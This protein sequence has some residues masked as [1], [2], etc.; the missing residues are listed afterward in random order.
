MKNE[1][2]N[3]ICLYNTELCQKGQKF[4]SNQKVHL[5]SLAPLSLHIYDGGPPS[6]ASGAEKPSPEIKYTINQL[7]LAKLTI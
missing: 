2:Q 4:T 5:S 3:I 1:V 7:S 6:I